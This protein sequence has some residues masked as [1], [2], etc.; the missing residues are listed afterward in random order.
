MEQNLKPLY[1]LSKQKE[2]SDLN[3]EDLM[4]LI[5]KPFLIS[6]I[7]E[8]FDITEKE[9]NNLRKK[10]NITNI[11]IEQIYRDLISI[12]YY[13]NY[14]YPH[15]QKAKLEK[16]ITFFIK[17]CTKQIKKHL[18]YEKQLNN[19]NWLYLNYPQIINEKN[20]DLDY[21][22][23]SNIYQLNNIDMLAKIQKE[24]NKNNYIYNLKEKYKFLLYQ[25]NNGQTFTKDDLTYDTL[26]QLSIIES[27]SDEN[28][29]E[30]YN[31]SKGQVK[32][33][34]KKYNLENA[35]AKRMLNHPEFQYNHFYIENSTPKTDLFIVNKIYE[36]M[37]EMTPKYHW[38]I[39]T[40]NKYY[41]EKIKE[42]DDLTTICNS[43][44]N[45]EEYTVI[46]KTYTYK[47]KA[48][49][50]NKQLKNGR[51]S[52]QLETSKSKIDSGKL[53]E[54]IIYKD[55]IKK[56]KQLN[57]YDLIDQV[58]WVTKTETKDQTLD[59]LGYDIISYNEKGEKIYIEVKCSVTNKTDKLEFNISDKEV[60]FMLGK[61]NGID[62][63]HCFIYYVF[64]I[65]KE[66]KTAEKY[67]INSKLFAKLTLIPTSY[68]VSGLL[69]D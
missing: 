6:E 50:K 22:F 32:N 26:Y 68:K 25:K 21:R 31:L 33:L 13:A 69:I 59:G 65:N 44:N 67:I 40:I 24:E 8:A 48:P 1:Q 47:P 43:C 27:V 17:S 45:K 63:D 58:I 10:Y 62:K 5:E 60:N 30:L 12:L 66:S 39:N 64:N 55:E 34:R 52:N 53:G 35:F 49:A 4:K 20:I 9:F 23:N 2:F 36:E 37:L 11:Y 61:L 15:L 54:K 29:G 18:Y 19:I 46:T 41:K 14:K 3:S 57:R 56:L 28:I 51:K 38:N 16:Y 42:F 7:I